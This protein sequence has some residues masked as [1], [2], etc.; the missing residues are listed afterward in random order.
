LGQ[1]LSGRLNPDAAVS[2]YQESITTETYRLGG[3][4][5]CALIILPVNPAVPV[6]LG[7]SC[8]GALPEADRPA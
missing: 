4:V 5:I 7:P 3:D 8:I 6:T 2:K 1:F